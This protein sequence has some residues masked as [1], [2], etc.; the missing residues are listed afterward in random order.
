[1]TEIFVKLARG[2]EWMELAAEPVRT[3]AGTRYSP[4][5]SAPGLEE[6]SPVFQDVLR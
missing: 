4:E 1:M 3:G 5:H 2:C 6:I